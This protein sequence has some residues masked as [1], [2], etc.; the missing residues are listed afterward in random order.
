M[1]YQNDRASSASAF[2]SNVFFLVNMSHHIHIELCC[3]YVC[4]LTRR[5]TGF[6]GFKLHRFTNQQAPRHPNSC[7]HC[8]PLPRG[9]MVWLRCSMAWPFA[10]AA[11]SEQSAYLLNP[12]LIPFS[13]DDVLPPKRSAKH[14]FVF[15]LHRLQ[16]N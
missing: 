13:C 2:P 4:I 8:M 11:G 15:S 6:F 9:N 7:C 12:V 14:C 10:K 1:H 3:I 5:S 16:Q